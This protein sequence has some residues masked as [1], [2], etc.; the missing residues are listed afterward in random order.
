MSFDHEKL[1]VY[2][3]AIDFV[4]RANDAVEGGGLGP[5]PLRNR[6]RV[7]GGARRSLIPTSDRP[8]HPRDPC[9]PRSQGRPRGEGC[10]SRTLQLRASR[11]RW[12]RAADGHA[13]PGSRGPPGSALARATHGKHVTGVS[14][15]PTKPSASAHLP[16]IQLLQELLPREHEDL[17]DPTWHWLQ[18]DH[19]LSPDRVLGGEGGEAAQVPL[20]HP[21][22]R[23]HLDGSASVAVMADAARPAIDTTSR[24]SRSGGPFVRRP[25]RAP[26]RRSCACGRKGSGPPISAP[27][28]DGSCAGAPTRGAPRTAESAW[29]TGIGSPPAPSRAT[30]ASLPIQ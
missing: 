13:G 6:P 1:D 4:A 17:A 11:G 3:L 19:D 8:S 26:A 28:A 10:R 29:A 2:G 30:Q 9:R 21:A 22:A 23:L 14:S 16:R 15:A 18:G 20:V 25:A 5:L 24:R 27:R 12:T 7:P